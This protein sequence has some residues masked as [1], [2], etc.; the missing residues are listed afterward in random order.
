MHGVHV[1]W[2]DEDNNFECCG[3]FRALKHWDILAAT[4][5][6][7]CCG[8]RLFN[9]ILEINRPV[10]ESSCFFAL[11]SLWKIIYELKL[12][13]IVSTSAALFRGGG[14]VISRLTVSAR[15]GSTWLLF[16]SSSSHHFIT[17]PL[18]CFKTPLSVFR[19]GLRVSHIQAVASLSSL[20]AARGHAEQA[21][22]LELSGVKRIYRERNRGIATREGWR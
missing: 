4:S 20:V 6:A 18:F 7:P 9:S 3:I 8:F 19:K 21:G 15:K 17:H 12:R 14:V 1:V 16:V 2:R 11:A 5:P 13:N 10:M 22:E